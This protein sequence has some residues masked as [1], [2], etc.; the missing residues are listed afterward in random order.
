[1]SKESAC[2]TGDIGSILSSGRSPGGRHSHP[3]QYSCLENPMDRGGWWPTVHRVTELDMTEATEHAH[4]YQWRN[5]HLLK[6]QG[7]Q[8]SGLADPQCKTVLAKERRP[9]WRRECCE[10]TIQKELSNLTVHKN[11][12]GG[13][14]TLSSKGEDY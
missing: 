5:I 13:H 8:I 2:N 12:K 9:N 4:I 6:S 1:M 7:F 11:Q 3:F 10:M 14:H